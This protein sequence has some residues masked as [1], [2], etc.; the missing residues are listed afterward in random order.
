MYLDAHIASDL[1]IE[2]ASDLESLRFS[3][4]DFYANYQQIKKRLDCDLEERSSISNRAILLQF[5]TAAVAILQFG[6]LS[7]CKCNIG[8]PAK[9]VWQKKVP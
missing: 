9:G 3:S 8:S 5:E 4:G 1:G 7:L 6:H 2:P